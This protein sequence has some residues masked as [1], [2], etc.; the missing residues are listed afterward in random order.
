MQKVKQPKLVREHNIKDCSIKLFDGDVAMVPA[1][2]IICPTNSLLS[3]NSGMTEYLIDKAGPRIQYEK[4]AWRNQNQPLAPGEILVTSAGD[5]PANHLFH[6]CIP[7]YNKNNPEPQLRL[8]TTKVI[9]KC[10]EISAGTLTIPC[11]P[12]EAYGFL[13]ENCAFCYLSIIIDYIN[14]NSVHSIREFKLVTIDK[15]ATT[16][17]EEEFNRRFGIIEKKSLFSFIKK[18]KNTKK[19]E[20]F[21]IELK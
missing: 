5:L 19:P 7:E 9:E 16:V 18:K 20:E 4:S 12:R 13:P 10:E 17:F 1:A 15:N 3:R 8:F 11:L 2:A 14:S 6:C 21:D